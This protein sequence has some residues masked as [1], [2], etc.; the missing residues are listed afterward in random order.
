ML[1]HA[2]N[3]GIS[4]TF[5][6][7]TVGNANFSSDDGGS[8]SLDFLTT[9]S[10]IPRRLAVVNSSRRKI[11][12]PKD[13]DTTEQVLAK[14]KT[15]ETLDSKLIKRNSKWVSHKSSQGTL[16]GI[17]NLNQRL[18]LGS[19]LNDPTLGSFCQFFKLENQVFSVINAGTNDTVLA[20]GMIDPKWNGWN[21]MKQKRRH[22]SLQEETEQ[23]RF[24]DVD[25]R[26]VDEGD[27]GIFNNNSRSKVLKSPR[28]IWVRSLTLK[29]QILGI[30]SYKVETK[31]HFCTLLL[32]RT[33]D[34]IYLLKC[35]ISSSSLVL[36]KV[37]EFKQGSKWASFAH[38]SILVS[39]HSLMLCVVDCMGKFVVFKS[40]SLETID[41]IQ[42]ELKYGSFYDPVELSNFKKSMWIDSKRLILFSRTQLFEYNFDEPSDGADHKEK[43]FCRICAGIWSKILDIKQSHTND[44]LFYMLTTKEIIA[45]NTSNGFSRKFAWKHYFSDLDTTMYISLLRRPKNSSIE[46]CI[47]SSKSSVLNYVIEFDT[48]KLNIVDSPYIFL[49]NLKQPSISTSFYHFDS[50]LYLVLQKFKNG[51]ASF[52]LLNYTSFYADQQ[53]YGQQLQ[54]QKSLTNF[55]VLMKHGSR[56]PM[57]K[58]S[59]A[60]LYNRLSDYYK[61]NEKK[62]S[63][64]TEVTKEIYEVLRRF[65]DEEGISHQSLF[66]LMDQIHIPR[67]VK[68]IFKIVKHLIGNSDDADFSFSFNQSFWLTDRSL[69]VDFPKKDIE[70][71]G[72]E[73]INFFQSLATKK[74]KNIISDLTL[75]LLL[76]LIELSKNRGTLNQSDINNQL[77]EFTSELPEDYQDML[78]SFDDDANVAGIMD[79]DDETVSYSNIDSTARNFP[80][81]PTISTSQAPQISV[82]QSSG[83]E[84]LNSSQKAAS[85]KKTPKSIPNSVPTTVSNSQQYSQMSQK[86]SQLSSSGFSQSQSKGHKRKKRRTGF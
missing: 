3:L 39:S 47:I 74:Y 2:P 70:T 26:I 60:A 22:S 40:N 11:W 15:D 44:S 13:S 16:P 8:I 48:T 7:A 62:S 5:G 65:L 55:K 14:T 4:E 80:N 61:F 86:S 63:V 28:F 45:I 52:N 19:Q 43:F 68:N 42:V 78:D 37:F 84:K 31:T 54:K 76:G 35:T 30:E 41:F 57:D 27:D 33:S 75:Y 34:T 21:L 36:K 50:Y 20:F 83:F 29:S 64:P 56:L 81:V 49:T 10:E 82:S 46:M 58:H 85:R 69:S 72:N 38:S 51:E 17:D 67:N 59:S 79:L 77:K 9:H 25:A 12:S 66:Q 18:G 71:K 53:K 73:V 23:I 1:P 24:S 32:V 6:S